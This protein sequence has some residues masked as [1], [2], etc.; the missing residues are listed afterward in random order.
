[1]INFRYPWKIKGLTQ[2]LGSRKRGFLSLSFGGPQIDLSMVKG[3][4]F[5]ILRNFRSKCFESCSYNDE[6]EYYVP[7]K[8]CNEDT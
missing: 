2:L 6:Y 1:M 5:F 4:Y 7:F 8:S 3:E